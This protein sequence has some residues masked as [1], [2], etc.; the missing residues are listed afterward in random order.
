MR[1]Q[2]D[3]QDLNLDFELLSEGKPVGWVK[4]GAGDHIIAV[5]STIVQKGENSA[6]IEYTG[7]NSTFKA[8]ALNFPAIYQGQKIKLTGYIKT[9][10]VHD[11]YAG[12]WMRID[13]AIAFDN[14]RDR[15]ITGTTNWEKYEIELDLRFSA[16]N[17]VVGGILVGKGKMWLDN[18]ELSID[19]KALGEVALK[20]LTSMEEEEEFHSGSGI[21]FLTLND[22]TTDDLYQL[23]LIW[24]FLKYYHPAIAKGELNWDY[25]LFRILPGVLASE[26][27]AERDELLLRWIKR[28]G[29]CEPGI[30]QIKDSA[31]VK[32][33]PDLDWISNSG[34]S[35]GLV[36]ILESVKNS[37]RSGENYYVS[38]TK[39]ASN[40]VFNEDAYARMNYPDPGYR[41]LSLYRY[42]NIIQYYFPYKNLIEEDW[43]GV[44]EEF[45]PKFISAGNE[46][47]YQLAALEIIARVHDTH[48]NLWNPGIALKKHQGIYHAALKIRF[49]EN[50]AVLVTYYD[51][52]LG[53]ETG[54]LTGDIIEEID[55]ESVEAIVQRQLKYT[56]ASN[57][58]TQLRDISKNL[59]RT[60]KPSIEIGYIRGKESA[61]ARIKTYAASD[62]DMFEANPEP[63]SCYKRINENI[64]YIHHGTLKRSDIPII[65]E[66][67]RN[68]KGLII[69]IRNYP[70]DFPLHELN[71]YLLSGPSPFAK[72]S[73]G[74]ITTPGQFNFEENIYTG[75]VNKDSYGGKVVIVV[76]EYTQ[77]SAEFHAM[78]YQVNPNA[79]VIGSTTAA[80]DGNVSGINL[81][82]NI[83]TLISGIGIYYPDGTE[84]QRIGIVPDIEVHPTIESIKKGRDLLLE[85]AI[86]LI[87]E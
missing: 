22:K 27:N 62:W 87:F 42:W 30:R 72:V 29:K 49:I 9:E 11:G 19:G 21:S 15:G 48:A 70:L 12:L 31:D 53:K 66:E 18:L 41:I 40:P 78:A 28:L 60:N 76:N 56:P 32:I 33:Y 37:E 39:A 8:W 61:H 25:E 52:A 1:S 44:L 20:D 26:S 14:M 6:F 55:G 24:G 75:E 63:D 69:D 74:S 77:S 82:G 23:G 67:I 64:A 51:E 86:L 10:N 58:P 34:F 65:W 47:E 3:D 7:G 46:L 16:D 80:A 13:P 81:P 83:R 17:I 84:T 59:F 38:F 4:Y 79:V 68:T 35:P 45:I 73:T 71:K 43:K 36:K 85:K 5:D 57:Y 2:Y 54:M 50:R